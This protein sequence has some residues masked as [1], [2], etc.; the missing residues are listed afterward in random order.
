M[1]SVMPAPNARA[2]GTILAV[3]PLRAPLFHQG[4][5]I[6]WIAEPSVDNFFIYGRWVPATSNLPSAFLEAVLAG[7][8]PVVMIGVAPCIYALAMDLT[9]G[10]MELRVVLHD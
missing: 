4:R 5:P 1:C 9:D 10:V 2:A 8:D 3:L 7:H 6:G